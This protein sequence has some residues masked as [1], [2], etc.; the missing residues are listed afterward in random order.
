MI[1]HFYFSLYSNWFKYSMKYNSVFSLYYLF[2]FLSIEQLFRGEIFVR[3]WMRFTPS[4][5]HWRQW[6][7][8]QPSTSLSTTTSQCSSLIYSL[9]KMGGR[10]RERRRKRER[11]RE[12][13]REIERE[14]EREREG[15][16][17]R[18]RG[19]DSLHRGFTIEGG[20][21][22]SESPDLYLLDV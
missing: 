20:C 10:E 1:W 12:I 3:R 19:R 22:F 9:G 17:G 16:R 8:S 11:D 13:E 7:S 14:R 21:S 18:E 15:G 4:T 2:F 6:L 5:P